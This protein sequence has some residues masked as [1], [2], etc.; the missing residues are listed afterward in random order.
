[1]DITANPTAAAAR[2]GKSSQAVGQ[3]AKTA[4]AEAKAAGVDVPKNAQGLAASSIARGAEPS[5]VFAAMIAPEPDP[6]IGQGGDVDG[7]VPAMSDSEAETVALADAGYNAV[8]TIVGD[9][10]LGEAETALSLLDG[11]V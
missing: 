2:P 6:V 11:T 1:M 7:P 3:M 10:A 8:A 9:G 5:S 4:V